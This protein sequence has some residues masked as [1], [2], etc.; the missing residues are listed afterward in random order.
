MTI[1]HGIP[2][3]PYFI[4]A[5]PPSVAGP[6]V[7]MIKPDFEKPVFELKDP[8]TNLVVK[9]ELQDIWVMKV[10]D[11]TGCNSFCLLAYGIEAKKLI[12][13]LMKRYPEIEQ[14]QKI[15]FLLL[16]KL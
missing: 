2:E 10:T 16:K 9:A 1:N 4:I 6:S 8:K 15:H 5:Q 13:V 14:K 3:H 7:E 11:V 12:G